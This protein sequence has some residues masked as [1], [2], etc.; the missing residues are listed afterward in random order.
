MMREQ[1]MRLEPQE[2]SGQIPCGADYLLDR[3]GRVVVTRAGRHPTKELEGGDMRSLERLG[4]FPRIRRQMPR[5]RERQRH[6][7]ERRLAT[8]ARDHDRR[9][10]E[11]E[12]G[13]A[14]RMAERDEH[15][16]RVSL[17]LGDVTADLNLAAAIA[18][19][20]AEPVKDPPS[21]VPLLRRR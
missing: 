8:F 17:R 7:R 18:V 21:S 12:L 3:D 16:F 9:F 15:F 6:H 14:R 19:L 10:T 1:E 4:A 5:I 11:I 20:I 2:L 13:L